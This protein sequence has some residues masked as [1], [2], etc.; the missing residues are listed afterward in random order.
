MKELRNL[1]KEER[2]R[3][4][5]AVSDVLKNSDVILTT[6]TGALSRQ[7]DGMVFDLVIIDEAAQALEVA[8]WIAILKVNRLSCL[9]NLSD[10]LFSCSFVP[11]TSSAHLSVYTS[12]L[13]M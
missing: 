5:Q 6:L 2:Q 3:Q 8:C 13:S 4:K 1:S 12:V 9:W 7:I 10:F 11:L